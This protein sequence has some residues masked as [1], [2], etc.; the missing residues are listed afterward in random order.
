MEKGRVTYLIGV[1]GWEHEA[2]DQCFYPRAGT[3]SMEKLNYYARFFETVEVRPSFWDDTLTAEDATQWVNAV[4]ESKQFLI[5]VKLHQSFTHK[6]ELKPQL[7]RQVRGILQE[8]AKHDRLGALLMQ[9][10][11][12]FTNTSA[13]RYHLVKLGELFS[14]FPLH[15]ELRHESWNQPSLPG[16]LGEADLCPVSVDL[17]RVKQF[18][19]F[20]ASVV[21]ETAYVR[22]HGRNEKGWLLNS[23]D[24][25]YDYLYNDRE[26]REITRR[27]DAMAKRCKRMIL[28]FNNTTGGK[29]T[30]NAL[31]LCASLRDARRVLMPQ[32]TL[33]AFPHLREIASI[34]DTESLISGAPYREAV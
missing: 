4:K 27:I 8:L 34:E 26:I 29:A 32:A 21:G 5:N 18:I 22:L 14:G 33:S 28:I 25:R 2:F 6:R 17:P 7:A 23:I 1:G 24:T 11:Y 20:S 15:V 31:Q 12:S 9:F 16:F 3:S 13:H 30:A 10:P 19:S